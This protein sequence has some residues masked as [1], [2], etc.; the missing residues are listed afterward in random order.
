MA[1]STEINVRT[2]G[3]LLIKG[4]F[5]IKDARGQEFDLSG[6]EAIALCRCGHSENKPFCDGRH[7]QAGFASDVEARKL[8][9][10]AGSS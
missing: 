3:P 9:L 8:P 1:D 7:G 2:N 4:N 10:P 6:R 5:G